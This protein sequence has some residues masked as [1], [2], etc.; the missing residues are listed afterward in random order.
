[1]TVKSRKAYAPPTKETR[2]RPGVG[3]G[4]RRPSGADATPHTSWT[5][6]GGSSG[7]ASLAWSVCVAKGTRR[8]SMNFIGAVAC[9]CLNGADA[10]LADRGR[11]QI[12]RLHSLRTSVASVH[13]ISLPRLGTGR[14]TRP[15]VI[16]RW[17]AAP[18]R[19]NEPSVTSYVG[20]QLETTVTSTVG[21]ER[22][23]YQPYGPSALLMQ[24]FDDL[25]SM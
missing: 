10:A 4:E 9:F 23:E 21:G 14:R 8:G 16:L 12:V 22:Q 2:R 25:K 18:P 24:Y 15:P 11:P 1:M 13:L 17:C 20:L 7:R 5:G 3:D 19:L 6:G